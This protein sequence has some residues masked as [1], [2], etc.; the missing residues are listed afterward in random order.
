MS[1][2]ELRDEAAA[3]E[4]IDLRSFLAALGWSPGKHGQTH[5]KPLSTSANNLRMH[6][7]TGEEI[8]VAKKA[9]K[10]MF[11]DLASGRGGGITSYPVLFEGRRQ[12]ADACNFIREALRGN[13]AGLR[14]TTS[15][16]PGTTG[17]SPAPPF[18]KKALEQ[19][20]EERAR[21]KRAQEIDAEF[22]A[23]ALLS[24]RGAG[25]F[26]QRGI[27]P[28]VAL[29][30][31]YLIREQP[32][33]RFVNPVFGYI[34]GLVSH[35]EVRWLTKTPDGKQKSPKL[36]PE[37][38]QKNGLWLSHR[39]EADGGF[40][41][42][43]IAE[44]PV[45]ALAYAHLWRPENA[46]LVAFGGGFTDGFDGPQ[47]RAII[48]LC[49]RFPDATVVLAVDCDEAGD[50]YVREIKARVPRATSHQP[51]PVLG[52]KDWADVAAQEMQSQQSQPV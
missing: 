28:A 42:I 14:S 12:G 50:S 13:H 17:A 23:L 22:R 49:Q 19:A 37:R 30:N 44:S 9:G 4:Q 21:E 15:T 35:Y 16:P 1:V 51:A 52:V 24:L 32:H 5:P 3:W 20:R 6:R 34:W 26:A 8:S 45:D 10:W 2:A 46:L 18:K 40:R 39:P 38:G 48:A 41:M 11:I 27:D 29:A 31:S 43:I 36:G 47:M 33:G 25:Y 7:A